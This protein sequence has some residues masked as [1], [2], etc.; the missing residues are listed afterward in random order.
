[1]GLLV[2][3]DIFAERLNALIDRGLRKETMVWYPEAVS[4][5]VDGFVVISLFVVNIEG[6]F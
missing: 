1:M 2:W 6:H 4:R 3:V 5:K